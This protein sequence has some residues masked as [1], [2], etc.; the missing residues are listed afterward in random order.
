MTT[1]PATK[2]FVPPT[3]ATWSGWAFAI[4]S[5][6]AFSFAPPIARAA[7]SAGLA[8][9]A[10]L[11][12][13]L[14]IAVALMGLTLLI[15]NP[16]LLKTDWHCI[17]Y[18][19]IAGLINGAGMLLFFLGLARLQASMASMLLSLS[20]LIALG[21]LA[22]RGEKFTYRHF[23]RLGLGLGGVYLLIGPTGFA[24]S[25]VDWLGATLILL[26]CFCFAIHLVIIQ[27]FL[28]GY[29]AR[30]L[31]FYVTIY[32]ALVAVGWWWAHGAPWQPPGASGWLAIVALAVVGTYLSRLALF[33]AISRIGGAQMSLLTPLE[34]LLTVTWSFF[35]LGERLTPIQ[36][37]G[38]LFILA[39]ALLA[40]RRLGRAQWPPRWRTWARA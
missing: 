12:G 40:I 39:S 32:M 27:W 20:P 36:M 16:R 1:L 34:T 11:V 23:I 38:G 35:F 18:T 37:L 28:Q 25:Q 4:S 8:P 31:S 9:T 3:T 14:L 2:S 13:R 29:D 19:V 22:L 17:R 21:L 10:I 26:S 24:G 33:A 6:L 30:M 15:S 5:T 7:I